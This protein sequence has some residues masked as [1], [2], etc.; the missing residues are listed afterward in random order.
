MNT[1]DFIIDTLKKLLALLGVAVTDVILDI[2]EKTK[3]HR[4]VITSPESALLIGEQGTRLQSLNHLMKRIVEK[5]FPEG[6]F[7]FMVD[8]IPNPSVLEG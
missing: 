4:F 5:K 7:A 8:V 3:T 2:D 1:N 6:N